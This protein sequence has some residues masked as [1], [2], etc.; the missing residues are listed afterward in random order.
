MANEDKWG[1][2]VEKQYAANKAGRQQERLGS[3]FDRPLMQ[4]P[5]SPG[6][7]S[8]YTRAKTQDVGLMSADAERSRAEA[9][10]ADELVRKERGIPLDVVNPQQQQP[11]QQEPQVQQDDGIPFLAGPEVTTKRTV[12]TDE[13]EQERQGFLTAA[14][15]ARKQL[16]G[17]SGQA[18]TSARN[19]ARQLSS[20][21]IAAD[22]VAKGGEEYAREAMSR[23]ASAYDEADINMASL[24]VDPKRWE[25]STPALAQILMGVASSAFS[26]FTGGS[27]PNPVVQL[28]DRAIERDV[29]AQMANIDIAMKRSNAKIEREEEMM[30]LGSAL[31]ASMY[32]RAVNAYEHILKSGNLEMQ[33]MEHAAALQE[34]Y[35][36]SQDAMLKNYDVHAMDVVT[37]MDGQQG[38]LQDSQLPPLAKIDRKS[39]DM[40][41]GTPS[42]IQSLGELMGLWA[43]A[44]KSGTGVTDALFQYV[45][46]TT[47]N[48]YMRLKKNAAL[49]EGAALQGKQLNEMELKAVAAAYPGMIDTKDTSYK[50]FKRKVDALE[51]NLIGVIKSNVGH[52]DTSQ[53]KEALA[54]VR[55]F[56]ENFDKASKALKWQK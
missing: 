21:R 4:H 25:D 15:E 6:I 28:I 40:V 29:Q 18:A 7:P 10:A 50:F 31:N 46:S 26:F 13:I 19:T 12:F 3:I 52:A 17:Y 32:Q 8:L 41:S 36:K 2:Y 16:E 34:L 27:G 35:A 39:H 48:Q 23:L 1:E 55:A 47:E 44:D 11:Q 20:Q 9:I 5:S 30:K 42:F 24:R 45:P 56:K 53:A 38:Q 14:A 51:K 49:M 43:E 22:L 33:G 54:Q 37:K